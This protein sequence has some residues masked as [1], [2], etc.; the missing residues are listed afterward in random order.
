MWGG[1][2]AIGARGRQGQGVAPDLG[3]GHAGGRSWSPAWMAMGS[4]TRLE[5]GR[6][7]RTG[8]W[9]LGLLISC[10]KDHSNK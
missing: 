2:R 9:R 10:E 4:R 5:A 7:S 6:P 3:L 8:R 1:T